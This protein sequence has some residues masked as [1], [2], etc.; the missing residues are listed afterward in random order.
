VE[1]DPQTDKI[2][3][4]T[5]TCEG[6]EYW[7]F[8]A[9]SAPDVALALYQKYVSAKV[10]RADLF[11]SNGRYN[12]RNI[13]NSSTSNGAMH[14]I[15]QNNSLTA[16]IELA[17]GSSVVR[18]I[19][20]KLLTGEQELIRCGRYGGEERHS[21]PHIGAQVNSLTRQKASVTLDN[22]IGLYFA[23][24]STAGWTTPDGSDP[25]SYWRYER[26]TPEKPVRA[27]YEVPKERG[28]T[29]ADVMINGRGIEFAA[30]ITDFIS[31]KL[32]GVASRF[33]QSTA[34][35]MTGCRTQKPATE[36]DFDAAS[37]SALSVSALIEHERI[38]TR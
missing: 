24:L 32:T 38:L 11:R 5:F 3:R 18:E 14:L 22:P 27:V 9:N 16:E 12:P 23:G 29:V 31:I 34:K 10:G 25:Q 33:G 8:L 36:G 37:A 17:A 30:Q 13:W 21:D 1:R 26:G 4:V 35:P 7:S 15:Q 6:P 28:F 20:G 19:D 2:T